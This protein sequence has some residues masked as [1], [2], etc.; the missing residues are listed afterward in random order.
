MAN[1]HYKIIVPNV[2]ASDETGNLSKLY[3]LDEIVKAD[4]K[5]LDDLMGVFVENEW[6]VET[7]MNAPDEFE[8]VK[9]AYED[10]TIKANGSRIPEG[11]EL[12]DEP[13]RK[14]TKKRGQPVN[15]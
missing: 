13:K 14:T 9:A 5:W 8:V 1:R 11:V 6:A 3:E 7:K 10:R 2:G 15:S 4:K 12:E